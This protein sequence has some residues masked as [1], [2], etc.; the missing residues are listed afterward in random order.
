MNIKIISE[1]KLFESILE[2]NVKELK[3]HGQCYSL[4]CKI[5]FVIFV[6]GTLKKKLIIKIYD[7]T[8]FLHL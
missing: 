2:V 3:T 7:L 5:V 8:K 6:I 1:Q 4:L